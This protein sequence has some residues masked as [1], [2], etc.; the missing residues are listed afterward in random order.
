[1][2]APAKLRLITAAFHPSDVAFIEGWSRH[3]PGIG[4]WRLGFDR[5]PR[6]ERIAITPPG[7]DAPVF[8]LT[9]DGTQTLL[10][11]LPKSGTLTGDMAVELGHFATLREAT[12]ALCQLDDET[13]ERVH[14]ALEVDFPR[15][16]DKSESAD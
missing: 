8:L 2:P 10:S 16:R 7:A 3:A 12:L 9:R 13:L 1:M 6:P 5:Q 11:R 15:R 14:T 4:G